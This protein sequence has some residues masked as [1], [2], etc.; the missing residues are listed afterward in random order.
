[1]RASLAF[2]S[3][4]ADWNLLVIRILNWSQVQVATPAGAAVLNKFFHQVLATPS[5]LL[6]AVGT[7]SSSGKGPPKTEARKYCSML[8]HQSWTSSSF[9]PV[10]F[11]G[12][13]ALIKERRVGVTGAIGETVVSGVGEVWSVSIELQCWLPEAVGGEIRDFFAYS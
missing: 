12:L 8:Q 1:V 11:L 13:S 4:F 7:F 9:F 5:S 10:N 6:A 3:L 2:F